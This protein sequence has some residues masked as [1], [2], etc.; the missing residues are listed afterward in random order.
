[1]ETPSKEEIG[2]ALGMDKQSQDIWELRKKWIERE[3]C[4]FSEKYPTTFS[5]IQSFEEQGRQLKEFLGNI[6]EEGPSIL[7]RSEEIWAVNTFDGNLSINIVDYKNWGPTAHLFM[8]KGDTPA[9]LSDYVSHL[10]NL[11][12]SS[13]IHDFVD[14]GVLVLMTPEQKDEYLKILEKE[15]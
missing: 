5:F 13:D 4:L 10:V 7:N 6:R 2:E 15:I 12:S 11:R 1:M 3:S 8:P 9:C 14:R